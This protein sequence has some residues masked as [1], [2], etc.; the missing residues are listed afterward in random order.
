MIEDFLRAAL[1]AEKL[2]SK[3]SG[4]GS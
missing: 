1:E 2:R 3:R 4:D